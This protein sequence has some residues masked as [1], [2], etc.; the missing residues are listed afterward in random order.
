MAIQLN[1]A[2]THRTVSAADNIRGVYSPVINNVD[3]FPAW[4]RQTTRQQRSDDTACRCF[5]E[6]GVWHV[7]RISV[8]VSV[9]CARLTTAIAVE[10]LAA[11]N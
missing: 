7:T 3:R 10:A 11:Q 6:L 5:R 4:P 2:K 1:S 8:S 9:P